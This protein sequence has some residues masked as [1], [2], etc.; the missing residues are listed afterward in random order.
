MFM[1]NPFAELSASVPPAVMQTYVVVMAFLVAGGTLFDIMHKK[2]ATYFFNS[3]R[4]STNKAKQQ[5]GGTE[6][7]DIAV[8]TAVVDVLASGEFC[9]MRRRVAHLLTMYGF[10]IYVVTTVIMV[11]VYPTPAAPTPANLPTL[12]Y[13]GALMVCLDPRRLPHAVLRAPMVLCRPAAAQVPRRMP[14]IAKLF[15]VAESPAVHKLVIKM[16]RHAHKS[17][18]VNHL[19][20]INPTLIA[21][22]SQDYM[23]A[24]FMRAIG[25]LFWDI[26]LSYYKER[27]FQLCGCESGGVN[28]ALGLQAFAYANGLAVNT[29]TLKK[30]AKTYGLKNWIEGIALEKQ[31]VLL[32]DD[33][34]GSGKTL[35]K[36][37]ARIGLLG[38]ELY[39]RAFAILS[40]KRKNPLSFDDINRRIEIRVLFEPQDF[41]RSHQQY[42]ARYNKPPQFQGSLI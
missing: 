8:R 22:V 19:A 28:V 38:F 21:V 10:V 4:N 18:Q 42:L 34:V 32:V 31:P 41:C 29:F 20:S 26:F 5:V 33:I 2:S 30:A 7:V 16:S 39:P 35:T 17:A 6:M 11:F 1:G 24:A 23:C 27:P 9:N 25:K 15:E 3:W 13:I 40:C 37:A 36:A 12:W 14:I